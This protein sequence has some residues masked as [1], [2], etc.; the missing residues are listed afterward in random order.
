ML[1]VHGLSYEPYPV[2]TQLA[3]ADP[4]P[5]GGTTVRDADGWLWQR[6]NDY[7]GPCNWYK[8][9]HGPRSDY[10][11]WTHVA[12]NFG[13]VTVHAAP[14]DWEIKIARDLIDAHG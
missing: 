10:E 12:G 9:I 13:P 5:C 2:G 8:L 1:Y 6:T 14:E 3:S 11:T 7:E 4:E